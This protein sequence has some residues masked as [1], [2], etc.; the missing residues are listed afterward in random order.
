[1]VGEL[2]TSSANMNDEIFFLYKEHLEYTRMFLWYQASEF[3]FFKGK[4]SKTEADRYK[5][6]SNYYFEQLVNRVRQTAT[7]RAANEVRR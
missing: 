3:S 5:Y 4:A 7:P 2:H 1:M 6:L